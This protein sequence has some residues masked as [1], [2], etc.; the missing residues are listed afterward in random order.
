MTKVYTLDCVISLSCLCVIL[1]MF[2]YISN[3]PGIMLLEIF[4]EAHWPIN[5][6]NERCLFICCLYSGPN[7]WESTEE[8]ISNN[9]CSSWD[10]STTA[11]WTA[12]PL[13]LAG[14]E[15]QD[16]VF[17]GK[18]GNRETNDLT[19]HYTTTTNSCLLLSRV[20]SY[21]TPI[22]RGSDYSVVIVVMCARV[23]MCTLSSRFT[24][25]A[26]W[27]MCNHSNI[28]ACW[29]MCMLLCKWKH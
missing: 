9:A 4:Q 1:L 8:D 25:H 6:N 24:E 27:V 2:L 21:Y 12:P 14:W 3:N 11:G 10:I 15:S 26:Q 29:H 20:F 23:N 18:W 5:H 19:Y 17:S 7:V 28:C 13:S 22:S 16:K